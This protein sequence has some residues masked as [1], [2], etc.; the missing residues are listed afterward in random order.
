MQKPQMGFAKGVIKIKA[1]K[2]LKSSFYVN[3]QI[4]NSKS[5]D[6]FFIN[7]LFYIFF[8]TFRY[9]YKPTVAIEKFSVE[10]KCQKRKTVNA[11]TSKLAFY[12]FTILCRRRFMNFLRSSISRLE[13]S[14]N[15]AHLITFYTKEMNKWYQN[16]QDVD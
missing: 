15:F 14:I 4:Q 1:P 8:N 3:M 13:A 5:S 11:A 9:L 7:F 12:Q 16:V 2:Y 6:S 10:M